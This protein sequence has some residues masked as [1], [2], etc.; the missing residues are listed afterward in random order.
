MRNTESHSLPLASH[1]GVVLLDLRKDPPPDALDRHYRRKMGAATVS[2]PGY[3]TDGQHAL[4]SGSYS[5]GSLCGYGWLFLLER[6][7]RKW[8]VKSATIVAIS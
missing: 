1:S 2:L 5:C 4:A 6:T 3:S 8:Q 7:E